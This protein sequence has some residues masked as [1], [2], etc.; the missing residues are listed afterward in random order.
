MKKKLAILAV[1]T[2][3]GACTSTQ[4]MEDKTTT[5]ATVQKESEVN[6]T[7]E[8][9]LIPINNTN[10][11]TNAKLLWTE[12]S[13]EVS[14]HSDKFMTG[15]EVEKL[16]KATGYSYGDQ[17]TQLDTVEK[18]LNFQTKLNV[19][20][21]DGLVFLTVDEIDSSFSKNPFSPKTT[22]TVKAK[23]VLYV[24]GVET[25][26]YDIEGTEIKKVSK[27]ALGIIL[28]IGGS[29]A[30]DHDIEGAIVS[31]LAITDPEMRS[32]VAEAVLAMS[33]SLG[34]KLET[35]MLEK[36]IL[37]ESPY[38]VAINKAVENATKAL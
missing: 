31:I 18:K 14:A 1:L 19:E 35:L 20:G 33:G 32:E 4:N 24:N 17:L 34:T 26:T 30:T 28:T 36:G 9:I 37:K 2:L 21:L 16:V 8:A 3:L 29:F 15:P 12:L 38:Q 23:A 5:K 7:K 10:D 6:V 25:R 11:Q 22:R 13:K 27:E